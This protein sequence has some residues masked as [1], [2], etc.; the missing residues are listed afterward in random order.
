MKKQMLTLFAFLLTSVSLYS[1]NYSTQGFYA[2]VLSGVNLE[3][4]KD[5]SFKTHPGYQV[6]GSIGYKFCNNIRLEGEFSYRKNNFRKHYHGNRELFTYMANAFYDFNLNCEWTP[7]IGMGIGYERARNKLKSPVYDSLTTVAKNAS[8]VEENELVIAENE[9]VD[10]V[11]SSSSSSIARTTRRNR[12]NNAV[13]QGI[14]GISYRIA[15]NTE[16]GAEYRILLSQEKSYN[17]LF[18]IA[19]RQY[20]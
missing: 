17:H 4:F 19:L 1:Q 6:G 15:C 18:A 7:Y 3:Y 10:E 12:E 8:A 11:E 9:I 16:I 2:G 5:K 14:A 20:F 13:W